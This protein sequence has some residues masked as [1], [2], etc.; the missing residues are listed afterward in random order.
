MTS[1]FRSTLSCDKRTRT[2]DTEVN[3]TVKWRGYSV[4]AAG[5]LVHLTLGTV[6]T[7]GQY[8][9]EIIYNKGKQVSSVDMSDTIINLYGYIW[10]LH[11]NVTN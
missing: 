4:V 1:N 3:M 7:F 8:H 9:I 2:C 10:C 5:I 6:Y 11:T